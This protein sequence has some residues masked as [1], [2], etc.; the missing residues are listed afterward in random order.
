MNVYTILLKENHATVYW[1]NYELYLIQYGCSNNSL[2][3]NSTQYLTPFVVNS[4]APSPLISFC[5]LVQNY[6]LPYDGF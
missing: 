6:F 2:Y 4:L 5:I 3:D 1:K